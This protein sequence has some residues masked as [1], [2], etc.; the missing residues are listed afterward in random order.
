MTR[1]YWGLITDPL[2]GVLSGHK[3]HCASQLPPAPCQ[4]LRSQPE[5]DRNP[6]SGHLPC[7]SVSAHRSPFWEAS[8]SLP[9][10]PCRLGLALP[11]PQPQPPWAFRGCLGHHCVLTLTSTRAG[12]KGVSC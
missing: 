3:T 4:V 10:H 8:A 6:H 5:P 2:M 11:D 7:S 1:G 12:H 9:C